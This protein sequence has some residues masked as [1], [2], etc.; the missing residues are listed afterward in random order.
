MSLNSR[1]PSPSSERGRGLVFVPTQMECRGSSPFIGMAALP[2]KIRRQARPAKSDKCPKLLPPP[3][4]LAVAGRAHRYADRTTHEGQPLDD[5]RNPKAAISTHGRVGIVAKGRFMADNAAPRSAPSSSGLARNEIGTQHCYPNPKPER[6]VRTQL[7]G[8]IQVAAIV[9]R[10]LAV[11]AVTSNASRLRQFIPIGRVPLS[12]IS[13]GG[14]LRPQL[15]HEPCDPAALIEQLRPYLNRS[16]QPAGIVII[17]IGKNLPHVHCNAVGL[18]AALSSMLF[19]ARREMQD[20]RRL[21]LSVK[22]VVD[23]QG[24]DGIQFEVVVSPALHDAHCGT[25][26]GFAKRDQIG[27]ATAKL[28]ARGASGSVASD[29]SSNGSMRISLWLPCPTM[30]AEGAKGSGNSM[31]HTAASERSLYS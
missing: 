6:L 22:A 4:S 9:L 3:R 31:V 26:P 13:V 8:F 23:A 18:E 1:S 17:D 16:I 2:Q 25:L 7:G 15:S 12:D 14:D 24:K 11:G 28:F 30:D 20:A 5:G 19:H 27:L 10:N 21:F 29:R